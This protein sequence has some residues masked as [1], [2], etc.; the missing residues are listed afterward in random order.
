MGPFWSSF[1]MLGYK[2]QGATVKRNL[3]SLK[4]I[5]MIEK[6]ALLRP[7]I[8]LQLDDLPYLNTLFLSYIHEVSLHYCSFVTEYTLSLSILYI[9]S[10]T[11]THMMETPTYKQALIQVHRLMPPFVMDDPVLPLY[12]A[13]VNPCKS[14]ET[15]IPSREK[16]EQT[17]T[18]EAEEKEIHPKR[19]QRKTTGW[20]GKSIKK[21][22][23]RGRMSNRKNE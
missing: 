23:I 6:P 1:H 7:S 2:H 4:I 14:T 3:S 15:D 10:S 5:F 21:Q 12:W 8:F 11:N 16:E 20:P 19:R 13:F 17:E 18:Q 22:E 9:I